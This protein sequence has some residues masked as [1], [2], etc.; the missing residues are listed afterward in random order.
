MKYRI[1]GIIAKKYHGKDTIA[2]FI[3]SKYG[4]EK[5]SFAGPLKQVCHHIFGLTYEQL[6]GD[7][8]ETNDNYWKC[9]P[10][11]LLQTVGTNLFR[12]RFDTNIC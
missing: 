10:R 6:Y 3:S 9:T 12:N 11:Y 8:K 4:Y 5:I 1:I 7:L 2:D